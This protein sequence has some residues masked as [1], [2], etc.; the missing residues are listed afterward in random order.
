MRFKIFTLHLTLIL[1]FSLQLSAQKVKNERFNVSYTQLPTQPLDNE[2]TTY[3]VNV[4]GSGYI[5]GHS[6]FESG[7]LTRQGL[8]NSINLGGFKKVDGNAHVR[9]QVSVGSAR[10][11][12]NEISKK[13]T[14]N[15]S[16]DGKVTKTTSYFMEY[17]YYIPVN[18]KVFD[19]HGNMIYE[20]QVSNQQ[21]LEKIK[22]SSFN[23]SSKAY[24]DWKKRR[25]NTLNNSAV[26]YIKNAIN[27]VS[28]GLNHRYGYPQKSERE[29]LKVIKKH[30]TEDDFIKAYETANA[31]FEKVKANEPLETLAT[32]LQPAI[33][34]WMTYD[35]YPADDRKLKKVRYACLYNLTAAY[36]WMDDLANAEKYAK[37]CLEID[38]KEGGVNRFVDRIEKLKKSFEVNE[39]DSRHFFIDVESAMPPSD[40]AAVADPP[41]EEEDNA[42]MAGTMIMADGSKVEGDVVVNTE[43]GSDL[44]FG[45]KGNVSFNYKADGKDE[46]NSLD[47]ATIQE[48]SFNGRNFKVMDFTP[49]AKGNKI[50][51]KHILEVI[52][53]SPRIQLFKYY[54]YDDQLGDKKIEFALMRKGEPAPTST[55]STPFL[56]FKKGLAKYFE[57]CGDLS[58]LAAAGDIEHTEEGLIQAARI[59]AEVCEERP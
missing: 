8:Q 47:P 1:C 41:A 57:D 32:D 19:Y 17:H 5:N 12:K 24:E 15:K 49:G 40:N 42:S 14:E 6:I 44:V 52:Y 9:V 4:Y 2:F 50:S 37:E 25:M 7:K 23:S 51:G 27:S 45:P 56:L 53:D 34:F 39:V 18:Y 30:D 31:A 46:S 58:G 55:S 29:E 16:K 43:E 48:F 38:Y 33:D 35:K 36:Y 22:G 21:N 3:R 11:V 28:G 10:T 20:A 54:P 59:Y 13:V 26:S